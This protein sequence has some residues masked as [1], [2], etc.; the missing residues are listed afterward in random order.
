MGIKVVIT[1]GSYCQK[2]KGSKQKPHQC[3]TWSSNKLCQEFQYGI[4]AVTGLICN[5]NSS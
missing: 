3:Q 5:A 2:N 4:S 1:C